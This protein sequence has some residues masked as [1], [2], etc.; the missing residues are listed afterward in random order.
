MTLRESIYHRGQIASRRFAKGIPC[1]MIGDPVIL[2]VLNKYKLLPPGI[3][4]VGPS[5]GY[6]AVTGKVILIPLVKE[7]E[8]QDLFANYTAS[9]GSSP[10]SS[11]DPKASSNRA[12]QIE[13]DQN[14]EIVFIDFLRQNIIIAYTSISD[15]P[16]NTLPSPD[17]IN[18]LIES[19]DVTQ[20]I[21]AK[22]IK[23]DLSVHNIGTR[24]WSNK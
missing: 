5:A 1:S 8:L 2:S 16:G 19:L 4:I 23:K 3:S 13:R 12:E 9:I 22:P 17:K 14:I 15:I 6:D 24:T 7:Q 18:F 20:S 21:S 11:S 10:S